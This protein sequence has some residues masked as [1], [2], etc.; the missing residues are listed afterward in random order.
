MSESLTRRI[1]TVRHGQLQPLIPRPPLLS[2]A[3]TADWQGITL[4]KHLADAEYVATDFDVYSDLV[5]IFTGV[6]VRHEWWAEG[7]THRAYSIAGN[8]LIEPKGLHASVR[9]YRSHS[10]IQWILEFDATLV[11]QRL[12]EALHGT[13]FA[14][15]PQFDL[16]DPQVLRL[17]HALQVDLEAGCPTGS[18]FGEML[19]DA[20]AVYLAQRYAAHAPQSEPLV[21]GLPRLR[22]NRVLDYIHANLDRDLH[23]SELADAAG[24]SAFHFAKLFKRSTGISP[25]QYILQRRLD[26]AKELLCNPQMSL[27]EVSQHAGFADQSHLTNVFRRFVGVTP[28]KFRRLL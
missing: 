8:I 28:A 16:Q 19:G 24:L 18:L 1:Q 6:P 27:S 10:D 11:E 22:L 3:A 4:E 15:T 12:Q 7:R 21:G 17:V 23:L 13:R 20:L 2:S 14:L 25:H 26:R 9:V 5:H